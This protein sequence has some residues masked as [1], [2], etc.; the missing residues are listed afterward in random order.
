MGGAATSDLDAASARC[1]RFPHDAD[2]GVRG[3]GATIETA[4][5][6]AALA[7]TA[8]VTE[9]PIA[10]RQS[11]EVSCEAPDSELLFVAWLNAVI[12]EMAT[13]PGTESYVLVAGGEDKAFASA[14]HGNARSRVTPR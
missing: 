10:E 5:E 14:C 7:L 9:A 6:Q 4:F 8:V 2:V 11:L 1:E 3:F 12:Y 13:R